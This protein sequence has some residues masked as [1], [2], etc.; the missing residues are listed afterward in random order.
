MAVAVAVAGSY[1]SDSIPSLG[2]SISR[3]CGPK[4]TKKKRKKYHLAN[5]R[6]IIISG[7]NR[8]WILKLLVRHVI[9]NSTC[10]VSKY[11]LKITK[12]D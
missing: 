2:T 10:T 7:K 1:S 4:K 3:G 5:T 6:V 11:F 9:R 12:G 8:Q